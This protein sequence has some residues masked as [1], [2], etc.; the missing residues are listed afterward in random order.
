MTVS[1]CCSWG[2]ASFLK[3]ESRRS[4][5]WFEFY[6]TS[7]SCSSLSDKVI[8]VALTLACTTPFGIF[9]AF[10][11]KEYGQTKL[12]NDSFLT[13]IGSLGAIFNGIGRVFWGIISTATLSR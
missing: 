5:T 12:T 2:G 6:V 4:S 13:L 3:S 8:W 1:N 11:Y 10:N 9:I 7:E